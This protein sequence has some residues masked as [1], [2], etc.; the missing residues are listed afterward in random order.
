MTSRLTFL[1]CLLSAACL[2]GLVGCS[3]YQLGT[4]GKLSFTTLYVEPVEN[5]TFLP[6]AR[7]I[8]STQIREAFERDGRVQLVNSAEAADATLE[9]TIRDYHRDVS[10]V[11]ENDTGLARKYALT[12]GV[13]CTLHDNRKGADLFTGRT[14]TAQRDAFT[15]PDLPSDRYGG[16]LQ[17]EF[18]VLPLLA[19]AL[20]KKV[21][22][23]VL[24]VW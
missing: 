10:S 19:E 9:I 16:Q 18:Q 4:G 8:L 2:C 13:V 7:A 23:S 17:S 14:I 15:D 24:D 6:Q 3:H 12:L 5:K 20:A 21:T 11:R 1:L 22:H